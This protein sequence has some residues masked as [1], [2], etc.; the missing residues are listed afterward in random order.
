MSG[1][2][3]YIRHPV[4]ISFVSHRTMPTLYSIVPATTLF[5]EHYH[6][7]ESTIIPFPENP[8]TYGGQRDTISV[9]A[10]EAE[11]S[12]QHPEDRLR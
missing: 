8:M 12:Y 1:I 2:S 6:R 5:V 3:G 7:H 4:S 9:Q 11:E 10:E